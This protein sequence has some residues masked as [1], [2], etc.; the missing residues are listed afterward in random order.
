M[1]YAETGYDYGK[2][3]SFYYRRIKRPSQN[4]VRYC[5]VHPQKQYLLHILLT[6]EGSEDSYP[7]SRDGSVTS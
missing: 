4:Q 1:T 3:R 5:A 2:I 6:A 7:Y